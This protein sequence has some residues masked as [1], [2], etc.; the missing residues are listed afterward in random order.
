ME[1]GCTPATTIKPTRNG[2]KVLRSPLQVASDKGCGSGKASLGSVAVV[3][4]TLL[5][6]RRAPDSGG[7]IHGVLMGNKRQRLMP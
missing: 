6:Y 2:S 5:R 4:R 3:M 7:W 1:E